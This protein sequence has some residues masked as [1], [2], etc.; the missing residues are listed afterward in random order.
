MDP[1]SVWMSEKDVSHQ[2]AAAAVKSSMVFQ[3]RL[4][5]VI[6]AAG[7]LLRESEKPREDRQG[8]FD[9]GRPVIWYTC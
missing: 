2:S 4:R 8:E 7:L 3:G 9:L 6:V 1:Q 5:A